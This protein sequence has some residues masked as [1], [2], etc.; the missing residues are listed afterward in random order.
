M[1]NAEAGFFAVAVI[2]GSSSV[3]PLIVYLN[4]GGSCTTLH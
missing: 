1:L 3:L 4:K 2:R